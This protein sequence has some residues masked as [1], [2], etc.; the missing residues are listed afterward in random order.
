MIGLKP[1]GL[2]RI[3]CLGAH[4]DDIEIGCGGTILTLLEAQSDLHVDWIV[5]TGGGGIREEEARA[6]ASA[7]LRGA[8][9]SQVQVQSF[10]DGFMPFDAIPVKEYFESLKSLSP[11][12]VLTH[13]HNDLHQD[14]RLLSQLTWNTFR[15]NL[16]LEYEIPK[17]DGGMGAPNMFCPL[18]PEVADR[19]VETLM[20]VFQS[21]RSHSW[22]TE[23]LFRGLMRLRGIECNAPGAAAEGYY[24]RKTRLS[25]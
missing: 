7:F 9:S 2:R 3:L 5:F 19:K 15:D 1:Q 24:S 12:L 8:R 11:D 16:V 18:T 21:Q 13:Y 20:Q 14:H 6:S 17:Y 25:F 4:S 10:R 23:D 22:F